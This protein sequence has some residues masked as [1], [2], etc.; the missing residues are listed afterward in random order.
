[1]GICL[2]YSSRSIVLNLPVLLRCALF[3]CTPT[4]P[5]RPLF[6]FP[7]LL[8][9]FLFTVAPHHNGARPSTQTRPRSP[10]LDVLYEKVR[11]SSTVKRCH[12]FSH[13]SLSRSGL[14]IKEELLVVP[15]ACAASESSASLMSKSERAVRT[16][17]LSRLALSSIR[18]PIL[19]ALPFLPSSLPSIYRPH[20]I[21][22]ESRP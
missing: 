22:L 17:V 1:M 11:I 3:T 20:L 9:I 5:S 8:R 4:A 16:F 14:I 6:P 18:Y 7:A 15:R 10:T 21:I 19:F 2:E 13:F 12:A